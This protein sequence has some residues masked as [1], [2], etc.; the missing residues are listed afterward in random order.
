MN[1]YL[2]AYAAA[3]LVMLA[4]DMLW[5]GVVAKALYRDG[6]GHL[7]ADSP[8]IAAAVAFYLIYVAGLI[9]FVV[10]PYAEDPSWGRT[11][12][13]GAL[14]GLVAYATY[15]LSNLATL[16]GWPVALAVMDIGWGAAIST[17]TAAAAR[18]AMQWMARP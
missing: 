18:L 12:L 6:I 3:L 4:L 11:L 1:K 9:G 15:D 5:L 14:F 10:A 8:N 2:A 16:K 7:M 17:V 13:V